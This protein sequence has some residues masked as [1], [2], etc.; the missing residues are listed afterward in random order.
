MEKL[1]SHNRKTV[2]MFVYVHYSDFSN[3]ELKKT[4]LCINPKNFKKNSF[5]C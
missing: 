4:G 1:K 5:I 2:T 3:H